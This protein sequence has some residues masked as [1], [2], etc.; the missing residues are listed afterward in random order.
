MPYLAIIEKSV[1]IFSIE[2]LS[3]CVNSF[4]TAILCGNSFHFP[5]FF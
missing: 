3:C 1:A 4:R 2:L 5:L